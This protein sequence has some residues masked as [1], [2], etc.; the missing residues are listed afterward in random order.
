[1]VCLKL[2]KPIAVL[3]F[4]C[5]QCL[6]WLLDSWCDLKPRNHKTIVPPKLSAINYGNLC[7]LF[8]TVITCSALAPVNNGQLVYSA[9]APYDFSTEAMH[10]CDEG[11]F[12]EGNEIRTCQGDGSSV[13]GQWSGSAP[14]CSGNYV[15]HA[16]TSLCNY[17]HSSICI[18][19]TS[20]F[21]RY[22]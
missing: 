12:L 21:L 9:I 2:A 22:M 5:G 14:V 15:G 13:T 3:T 4:C 1:M 17:D 10:S 19:K 16:F 20:F 8:S 18:L 6:H 11:Y 7:S